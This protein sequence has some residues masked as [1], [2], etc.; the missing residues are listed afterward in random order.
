M[1]AKSCTYMPTKS[2]RIR[3]AFRPTG[4]SGQRK[5]CQLTPVVPSLSLTLHAAGQHCYAWPREPSDVCECLRRFTSL[6]A[7]DRSLAITRSGTNHMRSSA[8]LN[9]H[10]VLRGSTPRDAS[11]TRRLLLTTLPFAFGTL[12]RCMLPALFRKCRT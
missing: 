11:T 1:C 6:A 10:I 8:W 12:H 3:I 7:R 2:S 4:P 9:W 5:H